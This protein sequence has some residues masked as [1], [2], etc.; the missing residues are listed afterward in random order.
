[1]AEE[2]SLVILALFPL[3]IGIVI[4]RLLLDIYGRT[5]TMNKLLKKNLGIAEVFSANRKIKTFQINLDDPDFTKGGK[6]YVI[7][8]SKGY[9]R[10]TVSVLQYFADDAVPKSPMEITLL[11][12]IESP[13][14][15]QSQ[16]RNIFSLMISQIMNDESKMVRFVLIAAGI[17]AL[18]GLVN[19]IFSMGA[20][21]A[22][23]Q[24]VDGLSAL[25]QS[26][27]YR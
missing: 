5:E 13:A 17:G 23:Q 15:L 8:G 9:L 27:Y 25:N 11:K 19:V 24:C 12:S 22:A 16:K 2:L 6:T 10:G 20:G 14:V 4:S 3:L 18:L 26:L 21:T 1:M 7:D